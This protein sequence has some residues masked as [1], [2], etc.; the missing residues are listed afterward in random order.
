MAKVF[1]ILIILFSAASEA[2]ADDCAGKGLVVTAPRSGTKTMHPSITV[3]G[4]LCQNHPLIRIR[5]QTTD[6]ETLTET[7]E[8]CD[9]GRQDC[10]YHFAAPV[11]G[12]EMGQNRI[13]AE[14][15]G[16]GS[17]EGILVEIEIIRTALAGL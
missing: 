16:E 6:V 17:G 14:V 13:T 1:I 15:L 9:K 8:V 11:R 2:L 4:Y 12:L 7:S 5:N 3:R 10:T